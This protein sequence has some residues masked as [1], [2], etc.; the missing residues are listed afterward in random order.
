[1]WDSVGMRLSQ[2]GRDV[3]IPPLVRGSTDLLCPTLRDVILYTFTP[4]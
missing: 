2:R 1:M 3:V 4:V